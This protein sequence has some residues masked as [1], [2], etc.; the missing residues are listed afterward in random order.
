L[1]LPRIDAKLAAVLGGMVIA[2][3][4]LWSLLEGP[5]G[6]LAY[7]LVDEPAHLA[8]CALA[9]L[10]LAAVGGRRISGPFVVAALVTSVAI[11]LDHLPG[12][13][14]SDL[15]SGGTPRPYTHSAFVVVL[16]LLAAWALRGQR[17]GALLGIAAGLGAHLLRDLATGPG[18][19][20]AWPVSA[21]VAKVPY[22]AYAV[23]LGSLAGLAALHRPVEPGERL[24]L[25]PSARRARFGQGLAVAAA[26]VLVAAPWIA[27]ER[28]NASRAAVGVYLPESD[29]NPAII[30]R[31]AS[32]VGRQPAIVQ[33]YRDWS[34]QPFE[35]A[36]LDPIAARGAV[37]MVT[38]EPW[39]DWSEGVSLWAIANGAEDAYI[40][41]A[42]R[43][44]A[45]WG[46][47]MFVRFAHEMNG[48]WYP[49]GRGVGGNTPLAYKAAWRHVVRIFRLEGAH[50]VRWVWTP[51]LDG[52]SRPFEPFYPGDKWVDWAGLDGFNWGARFLSFAKIFNPSYREMV[53]LTSKPLMIAETGSVEYGGSKA[54]WI[55]Q[56]LGKAL[57]RLKHVRALVWWSDVHSKG[58]DLRLDTSAGA[59]EAWASALQAPRLNPGREFLLATPTWLRRR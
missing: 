51:Y 19:S 44:A 16:L 27:P 17:R 35:P 32:A 54:I 22:L 13:L 9:L 56:A 40:A 39:R 49:W 12:A 53:K 59:F 2:L 4:L 10:A 38:W 34:A 36:V 46:R 21:S 5:T 52:G 41:T 29:W 18:L 57:P 1:A 11:D 55:R 20:L 14:G 15:L 24:A 50:N 43:Q 58:T 30:D 48:A 47:P 28:A 26:A 23:V 7:G 45:A 6:S 33:L 37:P 8:T 3:D 25:R 31:Y 42:A